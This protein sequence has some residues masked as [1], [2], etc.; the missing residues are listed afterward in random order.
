[1]LN[2]QSLTFDEGDFHLLADFLGVGGGH[3]FPP[4]LG[5]ACG[6]RRERCVRVPGGYGWGDLF[7]GGQRFGGDGGLY[8]GRERSLQT[9]TTGEE[10][11]CDLVQLSQIVKKIQILNKYLLHRQCV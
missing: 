3:K 6:R 2:P 4:V 1:M 7:C 11:H 10:K 5:P 8:G 9:A